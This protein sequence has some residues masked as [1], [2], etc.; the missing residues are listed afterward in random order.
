MNNKIIFSLSFVA[1]AA[2]GSLATWHMLKT[3][4]EDLAQE[5]IDS[6]KEVFAKR[7]QE[8]MDDTVKKTVAEGFKNVSH[9]K[10]DLKEY[11]D[12]LKQHGY[13]RESELEPEEVVTLQRTKRSGRYPFGSSN[14]SNSVQTPPYIIAPEQFGED[15]D[16]E[17][18]S[19]TY[20]ANGVLVDDIDE[21]LND[22]D[23]E[24]SVGLE[25]LNHFGEYEEDSVYV[26]NDS[27]KCDYEILLDQ[28][29]WLGSNATVAPH[30]M[31]V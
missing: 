28:S 12:R 24:A 19:L 18:I 30:Q 31:E 7:E 22:E 27:R 8:R 14:D 5:E 4:Y 17:R 16:Y 9:E 20:Y 29:D 6:V 1:G 11:V 23:V 13:I 2:I 3:K 25:S 10:P 15:D 26:R 21:V